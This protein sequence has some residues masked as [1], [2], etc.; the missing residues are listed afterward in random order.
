MT[1]TIYVDVDRKL[2]VGVVSKR[3]LKEHFQDLKA[4]MN[5]VEVGG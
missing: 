2:L 3:D 5:N 4:F 1:G